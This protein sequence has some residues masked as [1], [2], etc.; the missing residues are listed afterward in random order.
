MKRIVATALVACSPIAS[1]A[2]ELP[3]KRVV[4]STAGLGQ[5]TYYGE[6]SPGE[7]IQLPVRLDQVDD[8]LKSLTIL[9]AAN[10]V[11]AVSLPGKA[12][13]KELFRDLP[14]DQEAFQSQPALLSALVGAEVEIEG[15][16]T[17]AGR[18]FR[19]D[20]ESAQLPNNGGEIKKHRLTL[21]T[22]RGFVQAILEDIRT[23]RFSD[24]KT[25]AQIEQAL[26]GIAQNRAKD[27]RTLTLTL[28]GDGRRTVGVS[29]VVAAPVWKTAYRLVLPKEG[30]KARLQAWA[31]LENLTGG[32]WNDVELT[33]VSGNPVALKQPLYTAFFADRPEIPVS[34]SVRV[35]PKTDDAAG[36]P[37]GAADLPA[38]APQ[39]KPRAKVAAAPVPAPP[40]S[41]R[42]FGLDGGRGAEADQLGAVAQAAESEEAA[43][44]VLFRL[45]Y[46]VTLGSGSTMMVPFADRDI[47]AARTYLY[48]PETDARRP[49]A[50]LRLTNDGDSALPA[51]LVTAFETTADGPVNFAG[52]AQ[53]PLLAKGATRFVTFALDSKTEVRRFDRGSKQVRLGKA[54]RGELTITTKSSWSI[55]YDIAAPAEEDREI[56]IDEARADGWKPVGDIKDIEETP[57][58]LRLKVAAPRGKTTKVTL[59]RER[60]D[61]QSVRLIALAPDRLLATVS[62]LQ[63]DSSALKETI[64][65]LGAI[66]QAINGIEARR[67]DLEVERKKI[68]DDQDRIRKNLASVGQGSDLGRR[69]V[70]TLKSQEDRL[71]AIDLEEKTLKEDMAAKARGAQEVAE[72]L[73][74]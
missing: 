49:L 64:A 22:A 37:T 45:P 32:N 3:L 4:L 14:F 17:A 41:S 6:A 24:P 1:S 15:D 51:G 25:R 69:Y 33:L 12:P 53:L 5:F 61:F 54:V 39:E 35:V 40:P 30:G 74:L 28:A 8:V 68:G 10:S 71:A 56:V 7:A 11:G 57:S 48:Q 29:Y 73:S 19:I 42:A 43:T 62:G 2:S 20:E 34:S 9:D 67:R 26:S 31:V 38:G 46:K 50:A 60:T 47:G 21:L 16:V 55:D 63:N 27:Q 58:R 66:V 52:D 18:V 59:W 70:E 44:Q 65:K 36:L 72:A 13:L 23:L